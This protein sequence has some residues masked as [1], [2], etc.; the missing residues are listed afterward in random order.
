MSWLYL[1]VSDLIST[2]R[3]RAICVMGQLS[4]EQKGQLP[5]DLPFARAPPL[6]TASPQVHPSNLEG[7]QSSLPTQG[8]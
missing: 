3:A 6:K 1:R 4:K 7:G 8:E 5:G 2:F